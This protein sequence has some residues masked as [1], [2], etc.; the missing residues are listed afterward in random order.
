MI[1]NNLPKK[2]S[3]FHQGYFAPKNPKKYIG[4]VRKIIYRS[5][6]EKRYYKYLDENPSVIAWAAEEFFIPYI[7]PVDGKKH[8]YFVD[9]IFKLSNGQ[10]I[11]AEIKPSSECREP[12]K[13]KTANKKSVAK[14]EAAK[15]TYAINQAK[16]EAAEAF[17]K[18]KGMFFQVLTEKNIPKSLK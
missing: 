3:P 15:R 13:P 8:R 2:N 12:K 5:G 9:T 18:E 10:R 16:W 4:D 11:V 1:K 7:S 17:C 14:Y 6:M